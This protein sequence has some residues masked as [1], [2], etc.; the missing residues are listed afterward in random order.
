M[1]TSEELENFDIFPKEYS[2]SCLFK[3]IF[4][5]LSLIFSFILLFTFYSDEDLFSVLTMNY[6]ANYNDIITTDYLTNKL[7]ELNPKNYFSDNVSNFIKYYEELNESIFFKDYIMKSSPCLIKNSG[8]Y[9]KTQKIFKMGEEELIK[10]ISNNKILFEN[11]MNPYSQFFHDDYKYIRTS[12]KNFI[13]MSQNQST[14][15]YYFL[16]EYPITNYLNNI[17]DFSYEKNISKNNFIINELNFKG[18]YLSKSQSHI[19]IWGHMEINDEIICVSEGNLEFILIPPQE[20]KYV[21]PYIDKGPI[22]YSRLNFFEQKRKDK[23]D[24]YKDF[25]K[26]NKIYMNVLQGEC[27]YVPAFWWRSYRNSKKKNG[28][29]DFLTFKYLSNSKYLENLMYIKNEF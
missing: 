1:L 4:Y 7:I 5:S 15:N 22:N 3:F 14:N 27:V 19:V 29:C 6:F 20:K 8:K 10:D 11:K 26:A 12:Y 21:Y 28:K 2:W 13:A 25:V 18:I 17:S 24:I 9:F 23:N 16:N